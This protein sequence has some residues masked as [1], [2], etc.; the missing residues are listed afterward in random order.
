MRFLLFAALACGCGGVIATNV[1]GSVS[2]ASTNGDVAPLGTVEFQMQPDAQPAENFMRATFA[3]SP[4]LLD[5]VCHA[6]APSSGCNVTTCDGKPT[7]AAQL[8]NAGTLTLSGGTYFGSV[9]LGGDGN[10]MGS[11]TFGAGDILNVS[12]SGAGVTAFDASVIAPALIVP[13]PTPGAS[14]PV[15]QDLA[16]T[17]TGGEA[18][19]S[20]SFE[21]LSNQ[22]LVTC[23][24]DASSGAGVMPA[25]LLAPF[26][27]T[28]GALLWS[29][30]RTHTVFAG[31]YPV[32]IGASQFGII[33]TSFD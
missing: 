9:T 17:W 1:D 14:T 29:Q 22:T 25:S 27:G 18:G 20:V 7:P 21:A 2:D 28:S 11:G 6:P 31:S 32:A 24:F 5:S 16:F 4:Q 33:A 15:T 8:L 19:A 3:P 12:A 10:Y 23:A 13:T 30:T 26:K